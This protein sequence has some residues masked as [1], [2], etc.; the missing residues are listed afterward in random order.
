ML[1]RPRVGSRP[2]ARDCVV[3]FWDLEK[4]TGDD[5]RA[6][7][8]K[9]HFL[10]EDAND[11]ELRGR[12]GRLVAAAHASRARVFAA[13]FSTGVFA[14]YETSG[15]R[16]CACVHRL[17]VARG[18]IDAIALDASGSRVA[19]GSRR[20]GQ[21]VVW[22]WR[23]ESFV[24]K[25]QGHDHAATCVA[26]SPDGRVVASGADDRKVELPRGN[27]TSTSHSFCQRNFGES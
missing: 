27:Q 13:A 9:K 24:L 21:L 8:G 22:D 17:S 12:D 16:R 1:A 23:A 11:G 19:L 18:S 20:F 7:L 6:S 26:W 5:R 25:Q 10:W 14:V 4:A 15:V 2:Q 3:C